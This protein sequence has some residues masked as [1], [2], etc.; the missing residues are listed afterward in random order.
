MIA[1]PALAA[2]NKSQPENADVGAIKEKYWA[3]GDEN[4]LGVVQN[5]LYSKSHKVE[6][7]F[8]GGLTSSDPFLN[9]KQLGGSLGY[10]ISELWAVHAL[11]WK[12]FT[13]PSSAQT[14]LSKDLGGALPDTN[15]PQAF[16]GG[17]VGFSPIYGKLSLMGSS[18]IYYDFHLLA[19]GGATKTQSG[20]YMTP[21]AGLG[22]QIWVANWMSLR[23][24]YRLMTYQEDVLEK[25]TG[26]PTP[27]GGVVEA[28]R[29]NWTNTV[30]LGV[31]FLVG[32]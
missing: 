23:I 16:Y 24:D 8:F 28:G 14:E 10:H 31:T 3:R 21:L 27:V 26:A 20:T 18:I 29:R 13:S 25:N 32:G 7:G 15:E 30:T 22:Q 2:G 6:L 1:Q 12:S 19:G 17:E 9:T 11:A 5:R 4:E